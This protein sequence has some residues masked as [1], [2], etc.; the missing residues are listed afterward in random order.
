MMKKFDKIGID[1][2]LIPVFQP[3]P[4]VKLQP[5]EAY[6]RDYI[7]VQKENAPLM[8]SSEMIVP[9]P[10]GIGILYPGEAIQQE[11]LE[12]LNDDAGVIK[13]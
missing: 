12:Y 11:H 4:L 9:Y 3:Y 7:Y 13:P 1:K 2:T 6:N 10:P 8:L 5:W